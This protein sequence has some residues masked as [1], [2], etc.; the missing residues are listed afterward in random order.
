MINR[1][2]NYMQFINED[3]SND[4]LTDNDLYDIAKWGLYDQYADSGCWD[5]NNLEQAIQCAVED[6]KKFLNIPYPEELGNIPNKPTIYR[7]IRLKNISDLNKEKLGISWFS[8][9]K[10]PE[11]SGFFE[12]LDYLKPN[13]NDDGTVYILTG[14]IDRKNIDMP[15]TLWERSTQWWEN[16][17]VVKDDSKIELL[18][19]KEFK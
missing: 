1:I 13:K 3:Y 12:M 8:N 5:D 18:D 9:P 2:K 17:I 11:K 7:L 19:I 10:Q 6:F 14:K 4:K 16:E 15:R